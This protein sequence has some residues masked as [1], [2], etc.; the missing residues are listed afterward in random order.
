MTPVTTAR[1]FSPVPQ[2]PSIPCGTTSGYGC[3]TSRI[4][5]PVQNAQSNR[6]AQQNHFTKMVKSMGRKE[7][8]TPGLWD[9]IKGV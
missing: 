7:T 4:K 8:Q 2:G 9:F 1:S 3:F 5:Q 6:F